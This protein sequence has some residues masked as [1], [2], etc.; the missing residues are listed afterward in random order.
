MLDLMM[1]ADSYCDFKIRQDCEKIL[2]R[3]ITTENA[4][5]LVRNAS[6]ANALVCN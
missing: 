5:F 2:I 1:L 3:N 6:L 4:V